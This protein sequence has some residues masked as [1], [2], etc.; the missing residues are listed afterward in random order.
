[1]AAKSKKQDGPAT[2]EVL[3]VQQ[4]IVK[5]HLIG[6][7]PFVC[8]A[9]SAKTR[10]GLLLPSK[11]KNK[12]EKETT[13]KHEPLPEYRRSAY[14]SR[15]E[16]APTRILMPSAAFKQSMASAALEL[17]G[18]N[19]SQIGRLVW[20]QDDYV[21][22]YG[23]PQMWTAMV[24]SADMKRTP[25]IRT[26]AILPRWAASIEVAFVTPQLNAGAVANLLAAGGVFIGVGDGRPQKGA[27]AYGRFELV[28]PTDRRYLE[29]VKAG[30]REAQDQAFADPTYYDN[31]TAELM[32]W[33]DAEVKRRGFSVA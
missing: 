2:I 27:L 17:P 14:Q 23:V 31:E 24:R 19:K 18:T 9:M 30:G 10:Q 32:E 4:Q 33:Y 11:K 16:K 6:V 8:N 22:I 26:R 12:T 5:F 20:V 3:R 15:D 29:I 21:S 25:D 7:S 28:E 1:M 13:L